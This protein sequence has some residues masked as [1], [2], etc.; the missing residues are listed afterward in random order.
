[1]TGG[2]YI[3]VDARIDPS[4]SAGSVRWMRESTLENVGEFAHPP[5][6]FLV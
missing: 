2:V 5:G 1:M 3:E 4:W 6:S